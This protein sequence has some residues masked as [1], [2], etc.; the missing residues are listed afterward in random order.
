[1]WFDG[2]MDADALGEQQTLRVFQWCFLF[3]MV[4]KRFDVCG[5]IRLF[6]VKNRETSQNWNIIS[7][8]PQN[9]WLEDDIPFRIPSFQGFCCCWFHVGWISKI[10]STCSR[11]VIL[12]IFVKQNSDLTLH[13][14]KSTWNLKINIWKRRFLLETISFRFHV[15]I[16]HG[17]P[18]NPHPGNS[19]EP[20]WDGKVTP[21]MA[22][23]P[24]TRCLR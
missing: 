17:V 13:P 6:V 3:K 21:W 1:M 18:E 10:R 8:T 7:T 19:L 4:S 2:W 11:G 15:L 24:S 14:G 9:C 5:T 12:M 20:F 22:K 23:W 16:F